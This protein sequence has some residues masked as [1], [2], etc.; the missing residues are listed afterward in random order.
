MS[1][2]H[3]SIKKIRTESISQLV[4]FALSFERVFSQLKI[5]WSTEWNQLKVLQFQISTI[6]FQTTKCNAEGDCRQFNKK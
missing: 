1:F 4:E 6:N 5:L 3:F 2:T